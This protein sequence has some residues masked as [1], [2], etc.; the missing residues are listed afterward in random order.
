MRILRPKETEARVGL[1]DRELR[2]LERDGLFPKRFTLNPRGGRAVGHLETEVDQWI[3]ER[4]A[5][6]GEFAQAA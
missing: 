6:R 5:T 3:S 4:A 2:D 1:C